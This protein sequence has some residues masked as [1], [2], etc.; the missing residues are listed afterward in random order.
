M[1]FFAYID[2]CNFEFHPKG[3]TEKRKK[4]KQ[5][6]LDISN[7]SSKKLFCHF[8]CFYKLKI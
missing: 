5:T 3:K 6:I 4:K 1:I 7:N 8:C 2:I